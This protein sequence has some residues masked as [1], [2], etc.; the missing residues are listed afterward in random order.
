MPLAALR[1]LL[2]ARPRGVGGKDSQHHET[3]AW[4]VTI[5]KSL[6]RNPTSGAPSL[7]DPTG[8]LKIDSSTLIKVTP[9]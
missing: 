4:V 6:N 9:R 8:D 2:P 5:C 7:R 3:K 1:G